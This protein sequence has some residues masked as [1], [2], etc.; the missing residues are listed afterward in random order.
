LFGSTAAAGGAGGGGGGLDAQAATAIA[1]PSRIAS[2]LIEV[3][4]YFSIVPQE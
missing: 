3:S 4:P 2:V 1:P